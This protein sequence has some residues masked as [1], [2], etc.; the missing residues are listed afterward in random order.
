MA[1]FDIGSTF[2]EHIIR[3][4]AG[5]GGMGVVYRAVH[6]ALKR[7]VALKVITSDYSADEEFRARFQRESEAAASIQHPRVIPIYH[8]GEADGLLYVTMRFVEGTDLSRLLML[9]GRLDAGFAARLTAQVADALAAA[10]AV[11]VVH[12]DVKP[13]NILLDAD[14]SAVL[15]DFGLT[16]SIRA[17][18]KLTRDGVFLGT[19][20][21]AAPEQVRG[22]KVD[23]RTDLYSLGCVLYQALS[24]R[25]P[26]PAES[27]AAKMV[28]HMETPPPSVS[29]LN[30]NVP[31]KLSGIVRRAMAKDPQERFQTAAE[32]AAALREAYDRAQPST[33]WGDEATQI[34]T[35]SEEAADEESLVVPP[36]P[37]LTTEVGSGEFVGRAAEFARLRERYQRAE[38]G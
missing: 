12:R 29:I 5:R 27:D 35:T 19:L 11:G 25:V 26:Y 2:A 9:R 21:Y 30:S 33:P 6:L 34:S 23:A 17:D 1:E 4:V 8:A 16:K 20:D 32:F 13:G 7:E 24:G 36:P 10:H 14:G 18:R 38:Q 37:A 22:A 31:D 15:T 28:A 3:G